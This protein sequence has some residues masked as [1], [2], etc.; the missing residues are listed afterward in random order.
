MLGGS[1]H[2]SAGSASP[3]QTRWFLGSHVLEPLWG[4]ETVS[5]TFHR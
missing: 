5:R 1:S 3:K 4:Q 2:M